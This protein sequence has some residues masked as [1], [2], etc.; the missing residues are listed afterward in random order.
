MKKITFA[1]VWL[2][3]FI[4]LL[5]VCD[6]FLLRY[7]GADTPMLGEFQSFY[8]D[9]R[10]RVL[11]LEFNAQPHSVQQVIADRSANESG[12]RGAVVSET[13]RGASDIGRY[14][15]VDENNTINFADS[16][17]QIPDHLRPSAKKLDK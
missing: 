14:I 8:K 1:I 6:Q 3:S 15:Y 13:I 11:A 10:Q 17:E 5:L 2:I 16:L 9:L 12:H 7:P 4:L